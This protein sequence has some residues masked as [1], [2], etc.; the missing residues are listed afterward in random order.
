MV[1]GQTDHVAI[2]RLKTAG[3]EPGVVLDSSGQPVFDNLEGRILDDVTGEP[4]QNFVVQSATPNPQ[5]PEAVN[6]QQFTTG[7]PRN[8]GGFLCNVRT[9][10]KCGASCPPA[11]CRRFYQNKLCQ[12]SH[13]L[14]V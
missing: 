5:R 7:D 9:R 4:I 14:R 11:M 3:N 6:W 10:R 8:P 12:R 1:G 2:V 13:R